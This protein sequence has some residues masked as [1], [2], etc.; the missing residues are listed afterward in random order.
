MVAQAQAAAVQHHP[1]LKPFTGEDIEVEEKNF[2][3]WLELFEERSNLLV[4]VPY[5]S[6][7]AVCFPGLLWIVRNTSVTK[8]CDPGRPPWKSYLGYLAI[9]GMIPRKGTL[10]VDPLEK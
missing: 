10:P 6:S 3:K 5:M 2:D 4:G 8:E 9:P 1:P 7:V